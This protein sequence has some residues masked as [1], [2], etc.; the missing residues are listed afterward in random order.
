MNALRLSVLTAT[1]LL[2]A[3]CSG[4]LPLDEGQPLGILR[5][6][7]TENSP[8]PKVHRCAGSGIALSA[9]R[10]TSGSPSAPTGDRPEK[11]CTGAVSITP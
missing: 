9:P 2:S 5:P 4:A 11:A 6:H 8:R 1:L 7:G 10:E 3:G